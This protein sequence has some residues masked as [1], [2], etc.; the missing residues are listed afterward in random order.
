VFL[1]CAHV[2][3]IHGSYW[4]GTEDDGNSSKAYRLQFED[5]LV[6]ELFTMPKTNYYSVRTVQTA[7]ST[8]KLSEYDQPE[9]FRKKS[10][11]D[12]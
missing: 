7:P 5:N 11:T 10:A 4:I 6:S 3:G 9:V 12:N 1:A 2:A 8:L